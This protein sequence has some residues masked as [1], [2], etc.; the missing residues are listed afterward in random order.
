MILS[1]SFSLLPTLSLCLSICRRVSSS[2]HSLSAPERFGHHDFYIIFF[3]TRGVGKV[4]IYDL[5]C[6]Q[7]WHLPYVPSHPTVNQDTVTV[8]HVCMH[9][10]GFL[11][12]SCCF[13]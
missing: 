9:C 4:A 6:L 10:S 7:R 12:K 2:S 11:H 8:P 5:V 13:S 3:L 1:L